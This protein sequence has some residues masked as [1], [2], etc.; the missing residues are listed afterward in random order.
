MACKTLCVCVVFFL[1]AN[2]FYIPN[3]WMFP[4][5]MFQNSQVR[6]A[7]LGS[8]GEQNLLVS[9]SHPPGWERRG[10]STEIQ[11]CLQDREWK[12]FEGQLMKR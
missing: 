5:G 2:G 3:I 9:Q 6:I 7:T 12:C 1:R 11:K 10:K 8:H 4:K